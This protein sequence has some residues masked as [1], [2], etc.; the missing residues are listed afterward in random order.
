[1]LIHGILHYLLLEV[2]CLQIFDNILLLTTLSHFV[3]I[4]EYIMIAAQIA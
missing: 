2:D 4:F 1:M 3:F